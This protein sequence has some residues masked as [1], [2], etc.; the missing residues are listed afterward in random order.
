MLNII[1]VYMEILGFNGTQKRYAQYTC[2][3]KIK[4]CHESLLDVSIHTS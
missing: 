1:N 2:K 4:S 3:K